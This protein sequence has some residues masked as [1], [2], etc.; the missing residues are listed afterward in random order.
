MIICFPV[1]LNLP[2]SRNG[3][4]SLDH[5]HCIPR[6]GSV[7]ELDACHPPHAASWED[8]TGNCSGARTTVPFACKE[9]A[10]P[11]SRAQRHHPV[12]S[13]REGRLSTCCRRP[14]PS[15]QAPTLTHCGQRRASGAVH[16]ERPRCCAPGEGPQSRPTQTL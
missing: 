7:L 9:G 16:P 1:T 8:Q 11:P 2:S 10:D 3:L 4:I 6:L 12:S 14:H 15:T 5:N 13:Q